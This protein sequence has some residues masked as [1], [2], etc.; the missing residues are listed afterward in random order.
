MSL[1]RIP[2]K[3]ALAIVLLGGA[4]L[5]RPVP[6]AAAPTALACSQAQLAEIRAYIADTCDGGGS[7]WVY[8]SWLGV[9]EPRSAVSCA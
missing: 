2:N 8:C 3:L 4:L 7:V 9:W 6:A 5:S 1:S